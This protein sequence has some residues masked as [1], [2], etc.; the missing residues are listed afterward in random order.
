MFLVSAA[1]A[2]SCVCVEINRTEQNITLCR[3]H[4]FDGFC[5]SATKDFARLCVVWRWRT[6]ICTSLAFHFAS[7]YFD[8]DHIVSESPY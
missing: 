5:F 3:D 1:C 2:R 6:K 4:S 8:V 7:L